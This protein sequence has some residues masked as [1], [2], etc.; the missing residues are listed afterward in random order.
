MLRDSRAHGADELPHR[1]LQGCCLVAPVCKPGRHPEQQGGRWRGPA[2]R[3]ARACG[4]TADF[5]R[6]RR[7]S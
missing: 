1:Q 3:R 6:P 2:G 7:A 5:P 4:E